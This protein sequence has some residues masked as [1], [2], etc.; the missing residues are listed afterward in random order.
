[1]QFDEGKLEWATGI[2]PA[3]ERVRLVRCMHNH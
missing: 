1:L 3:L 2:E